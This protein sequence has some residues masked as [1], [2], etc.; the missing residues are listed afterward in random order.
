MFAPPAPS[1]T[2]LGDGRMNAGP[3]AGFR[4]VPH[5]GNFDSVPPPH[6]QRPMSSTPLPPPPAGLPARPPQSNA[7]YDPGEYCVMSA[8]FVDDGAGNVKGIN[9]VS[10]EWTRKAD[11]GW[12]MKKLEGNERFFPAELVLLPMEFVGPVELESL[13]Q[14]QAVRS[15]C[16]ARKSA[17][18]P[19][20]IDISKT[21]LPG[22]EDELIADA[23]PSRHTRGR[24]RTPGQEA[25]SPWSP[26]RLA[27]VGVLRHDG[28]VD[29]QLAMGYALPQIRAKGQITADPISPGGSESSEVRQPTPDHHDAP[30]EDGEYQVM[31]G[32]TVESMSSWMREF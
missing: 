12:D 6:Q 8:D 10:V 19:G 1:A 30:V 21:N 5:H 15:L 13:R 27:E 4:M 24:R 32:T 18:Q 23:G 20:Y 7:G 17:R 22:D 9:T 16:P 2:L 25:R 14:N 28:F 11:R 3:P 26:S 29:D 31:C